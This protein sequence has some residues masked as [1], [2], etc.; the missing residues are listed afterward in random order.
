[1]RN[2]ITV[3]FI[4]LSFAFL[5]SF[6]VGAIDYNEIYDTSQLYNSL[7]EEVKENLNNIGINGVNNSQIQNISFSNIINEISKI[8]EKNANEPLKT[9][10]SITALLL[11]TSIFS[12]Y[13]TRFSSDMADVINI[14][15]VLCVTCTVAFPAIKIIANMSDTIKT[16]STFMLGYIPVMVLIMSFSGHT[17]SG[18]SYYAMMISVGE[19]V[20]QISS[21]IIVPFLNIFLG[22]AVTNGVC[23]EIKLS[24]ITEIISKTIKWLL[25][26]IMAIFTAVL[27]FKQL[28][29]SAVDDVSTR[30]VRFTL[31]SFIPIVGSAL[32]DAYKTVQ[33]S[34]NLLKSGVGVFVIISIGF[35]F[36]PV[37]LKSFLWIITLSIGKIM[38]DV[39]GVSSVKGLLEGI[40]SVLSTLLAIIFC[41]MSIYI[42]STALIILMGGGGS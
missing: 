27:S 32:S 36:L 1:M 29:T 4:I 8:A 42:I 31:N 26:F 2:C 12:C 34:V 19:C 25:G 16:A 3:L 33:G 41:I 40:I 11:I 37:I 5:S 39:L 17:I 35:V 10:V 6:S 22:I 9:L 20:G 24:G 14:S 28:I 38:A 13:K 21:K 7:S 23:P 15:S 18:T 30:A